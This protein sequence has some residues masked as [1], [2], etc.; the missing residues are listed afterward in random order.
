M[1]DEIIEQI[2]PPLKLVSKRC[3]ALSFG[4]RLFLQYGVFISSAAVWYFYDI[5]IAFMSIFLSFIIIG[6]IRSKLRSAVLPSFQR[7]F[8]Y[9]D[10]VLAEWF[11]AKELCREEL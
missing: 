10:K 1:Q 5:F 7:E 9:S 3:M 11:T 6:I 2:E 4:L 8:Y